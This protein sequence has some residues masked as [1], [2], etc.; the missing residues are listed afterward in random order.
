M[1][2]NDAGLKP[3]AF[4]YRAPKPE[5]LQALLKALPAPQ[6]NGKVA[7]AGRAAQHLPGAAN[8]LANGHSLQN[9][10]AHS[11]QNDDSGPQ[12][13]GKADG[14]QQPD[15]EGDSQL[16]QN[17]KRESLTAAEQVIAVH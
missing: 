6:L 9:G 11:L 17:G 8:G 13:S 7:P 10:T 15:G 16:L 4:G 2:S 5:L 12:H 3:E 1:T 14:K